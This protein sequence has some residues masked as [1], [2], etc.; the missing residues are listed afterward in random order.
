[1]PVLRERGVMRNLLIETQTLNQRHARCM[2]SSSTSFR[3]LV[4]PYR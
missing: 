3:S 1:V 2:R 4:M